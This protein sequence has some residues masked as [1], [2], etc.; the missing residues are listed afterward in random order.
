MRSGWGGEKY[1]NATLCGRVE[2]SYPVSS[3][4]C[5]GDSFPPGEWGYIIDYGISMRADDQKNGVDRYNMDIACSFMGLSGGPAMVAGFFNNYDPVTR[6]NGPAWLAFLGGAGR[7]GSNS[8]NPKISSDHPPTGCRGFESSLTECLHHFSNT[9]HCGSSDNPKLSAWSVGV[10]TT[11]VFQLCCEG[12]LGPVSDRLW[13]EP[14]TCKMCAPGTFKAIV[15]T[16]YCEDCPAGKISAMSGATMC[17]NCTQGTYS[18][19]GASVCTDCPHN[20]S[21]AAGSGDMTDCRCSAGFTGPDGGDC[22][23][24]VAGK[25]KAANGSVACTECEAAKYSLAGSSV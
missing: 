2:V 4:Q 14:S 24:C 25:Y 15:G 21:S 8:A 22:M 16:S 5:N 20:T 19:V 17:S 18:G 11:N 1:E 9:S 13:A 7:S 12:S 6:A 3:S 23:A 10:T